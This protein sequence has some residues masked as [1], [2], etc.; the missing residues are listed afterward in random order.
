METIFCSDTTGI[1]NMMLLMLQYYMYVLIG[2]PL[3]YILPN[4]GS[5]L[6]TN[7]CHLLLHIIYVI[8]KVGSCALHHLT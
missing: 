4:S 1:R 7:Q 6:V 8:Y 2:C 3:H 5:T